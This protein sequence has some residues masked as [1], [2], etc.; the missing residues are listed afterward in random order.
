MIVVD[1]SALIEVLLRSS[2]GAKIWR[3]L[4]AAEETLHA[5]HLIDVETA[6]VMRRYVQQGELTAERGRAI[7]QLLPQIPVR[8][9]SHVPLL[10]RMWALRSNA[11]AYDA[12][13]LSL[14]EVLEATL[15]TCD[16]AMQSVP[17]VTA[18]VEVY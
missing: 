17:G 6:Q 13:Y 12:A 2:T 11:T 4:S 16:S 1:A 8:R 14:A 15:V 18:A 3:R 5:P 9:Y 10:P 7:V